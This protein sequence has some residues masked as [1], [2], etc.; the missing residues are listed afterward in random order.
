VCPSLILS[1]PLS[2]VSLSAPSTSV[3]SHISHREVPSNRRK[4]R[5]A[6]M[7]RSEAGDNFP[8][9]KIKKGKRRRGNGR[10]ESLLKGFLEEAP[11]Q[12][13]LFK[14]QRMSILRKPSTFPASR[15]PLRYVMRPSSP[16]RAFTLVELLVVI[17]IIGV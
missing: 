10:R 3:A 5:R 12:F 7:L 13:S 14:H 8:P 16:R 4:G 6:K 9:Q 1:V 11:L 2:P 15:S 17:A